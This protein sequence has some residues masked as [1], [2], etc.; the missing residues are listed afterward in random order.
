MEEN[1]KREL[2]INISDHSM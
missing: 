2:K 1:M